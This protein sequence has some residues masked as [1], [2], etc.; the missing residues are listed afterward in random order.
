MTETEKMILALTNKL[1][2]S[3]GA[4]YGIGIALMFGIGLTLGEVRRLN[5]KFKE[6]KEEK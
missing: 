5:R 6:V 1:G 3:M 4:I 2:K